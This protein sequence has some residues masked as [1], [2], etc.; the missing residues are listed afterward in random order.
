MKTS[1]RSLAAVH[2]D[3]QAD[4]ERMDFPHGCQK[5]DSLDRI[6]L[7]DIDGLDRVRED[8]EVISRGDADSCI[9]MVDAERGMRGG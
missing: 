4:D 8:A 7:A 9:T 5:C 2:P 6:A 1:R 3:R